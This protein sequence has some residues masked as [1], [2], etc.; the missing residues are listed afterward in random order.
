MKRIVFTGGGTGGHIFPGLAVISELQATN[1]Y[2]C[3]WL[4]NSSGM[5][6]SLVEAREIPFIGI[7]SGKLRRYFSLRNCTDLFKIA[8]AFIASFF[9]L[10]KLKPALLFSKGGFVSVPP[11]IAARILKIPVITHECDFSPGL[12]TRINSRFASFIYV[13]YEDTKRFFPDTVRKKIVVTGNPVRSVFYRADPE[14]GLRFCG[15]SNP[16]KPVLF[17]Q[18]GSL[19]ARQIN[20]LVLECLEPL[21]RMYNVVHQTGPANSDQIAAADNSSTAGNYAAFPFIGDE[22]PDVLAASSLVIARSGANTVWEC[23]AAGKPM[24]LV[25]LMKGNSRGDQ[26]ENADFF[27]RHGAAV[28][29]AGADAST[30]TLLDTVSELYTDEARLRQMAEKS[31]A[32]GQTRPAAAIAELIHHY[33]SAR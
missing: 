31:G 33:L 2:E 13:T 18:G 32:L 27:A 22:M 14:N 4:G 1:T 11:C 8:A 25:P 21:C 23:A 10:L 9:I 5:D 24:I 28:V 17:I 29:L 12:A 7:P 30:A 19:G 16:S 20:D 6:R 26:I 15:F 3:I